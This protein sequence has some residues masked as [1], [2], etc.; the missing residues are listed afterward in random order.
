MASFSRS[1]ILSADRHGAMMGLSKTT[2]ERGGLIL[3]CCQI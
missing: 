3:T 2:A 1:S